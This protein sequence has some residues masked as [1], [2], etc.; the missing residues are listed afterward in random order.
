MLDSN[1]TQDIDEVDAG[2]DERVIALT[3]TQLGVVLAITIAVIVWFL[4]RRKR[5]A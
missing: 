5:T 4:A 2:N 3:P 1:M